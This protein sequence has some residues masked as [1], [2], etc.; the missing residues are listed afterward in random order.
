MCASTVQAKLMAF[1]PRDAFIPLYHLEVSV[2][3]RVLSH[4]PIDNPSTFFDKWWNLEFAFGFGFRS[5]YR[6]FK[7]DT[8]DTQCSMSNLSGSCHHFWSSHVACGRVERERKRRCT[9]ALPDPSSTPSPHSHCA[10]PFASLKEA[11]KWWSSFA[12]NLA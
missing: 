2:L 4:P 9:R 12:L 11:Q 3:R 10:P 5:H 1:R 7:Y 6:S 8:C